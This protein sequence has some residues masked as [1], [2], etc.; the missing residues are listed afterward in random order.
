VR[1]KFNL[2]NQYLFY[3]A[4]FCKDKNHDTLLDALSILK[5]KHN[6]SAN[7]VL[8]GV[9][10]NNY[11]NIK[12]KI[13]RL[14]LSE[15]V[16]I[17]DY[18]S[19]E[20]IVDLYRNAKALIMPTFFGP[21]NIPPVE[22]MYLGVPVIC[23]N[24]FAMPDQVGDAGILVPPRDAA[25]IS[26]AIFK[27]YT[28]SHLCQQLIAKGLERTQQVSIENYAREWKRIIEFSLSS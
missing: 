21:T 26:D 16:Y 6:L 4:Q 2:P 11:N 20:D 24:V 14:S 22:A 1:D 12:T 18:V 17:L 3:P 19:N 25:S 8:V 27:L 15:Q 5:S 23:S 10:H 28:D 13:N 7:L 9:K